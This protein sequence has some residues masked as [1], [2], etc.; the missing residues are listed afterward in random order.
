MRKILQKILKT[1]AKIALKK[2][3]PIVVA[4]TGSVGKTSTKEAIYTVLKNHFGEKPNS[5]FSVKGTKF[6]AYLFQKK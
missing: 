4:I 1:L 2:Y 3:K 5:D 6:V